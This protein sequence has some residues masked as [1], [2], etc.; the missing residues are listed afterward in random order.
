M[1]P[2][3]ERREIS[4][5]T[6]RTV[7]DDTGDAFRDFPVKLMLPLFFDMKAACALSYISRLYILISFAL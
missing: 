2:P 1:P 5:L 3:H 7:T 6:S 4:A